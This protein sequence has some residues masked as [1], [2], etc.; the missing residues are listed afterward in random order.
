MSEHKQAYDLTLADLHEYPVWE[1]ILED[2]GLPGQN[3]RTVRPYKDSFPLD[4][5]RAFVI[6]RTVFNLANGRQM[7]GFIKPVTDKQPRLMEP[8]IPVDHFPVIVTDTGQVVFCYGKSRPDPEEI[9]QNY[10][11]LGC[12][13]KYVFP[14]TYKSDVEVIDSI[15]EGSINGF[16]YFDEDQQDLFH[17]KP[18]DIKVI[19]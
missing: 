12:T 17:L 5:S 19:I 14:I 10:E 6:V 11:L 18:S 2:I 9:A 4:P 13:P 16:M 8:L 3:E 1:Y 7:I 15:L